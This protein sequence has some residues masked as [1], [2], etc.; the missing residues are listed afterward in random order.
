MERR[1]NYL[2]ASIETS[3]ESWDQC[4]MDY[5]L[6]L[7]PRAADVEWANIWRSV[8][9]SADCNLWAGATD[10]GSQCA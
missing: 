5:H 8:Q 3:G 4:P 6:Q 9:G 7:M 1:P 2:S 10:S